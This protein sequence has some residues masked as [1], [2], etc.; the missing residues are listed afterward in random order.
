MKKVKNVLGLSLLT[1]CFLMVSSVWAFN[2]N[3]PNQAYI[4][5]G[6]PVTIE[7]VVESVPYPA[8]QGLKIDTGEEVVTVYGIGP[9]W[10]WDKEEVA[11]P[12]VGEDVEVDGYE[13]NFS[14]GSTRI[15]ATKITIGGQ[16]I[17]LRDD[18]GRPLWRG[19]PANRGNKMYRNQYPQQ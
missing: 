17:E 13:V 1:L 14:D 9:V 18:D 19:G 11:Y 2:T 15:V 8:N 16:T 5:S 3:C 10:Y 7:G 4:L 12:T 6:T